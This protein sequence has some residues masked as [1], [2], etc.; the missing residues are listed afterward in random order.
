MAAIVKRT[1][2]PPIHRIGTCGRI[3]GLQTRCGMQGFNSL[4][5][6]IDSPFSQTIFP[7]N[8]LREILEKSLRHSGF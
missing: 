6:C 3:S 8:P 4:I 1:S 7:V 5:S 2:I